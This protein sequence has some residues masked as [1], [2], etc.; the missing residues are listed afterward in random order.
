MCCGNEAGSYLRLR[1]SCN[2]QLK[3]QGPSKTCNQSKTEEEEHLKVVG[4]L[5]ESDG[6][7]TDREH[8]LPLFSSRVPARVRANSSR[9]SAPP[10]N[11]QLLVIVNNKL[12]ILW[13][14]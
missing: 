11:R 3:A 2:T 14:S 4:V 12:P 13:G 8:E 1:E 9:K 7:V 10:R 5:D 6:V